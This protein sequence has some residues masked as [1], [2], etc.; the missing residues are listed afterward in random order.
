MVWWE[1]HK[2]TIPE[3]KHTEVQ[4]AG[5][6]GTRCV[7]MHVQFA[8]GGIRSEVDK[9]RRST[10]ALMKAMSAVQMVV[11]VVDNWYNSGCIYDP[12]RAD[13]C[14]CCLNVSALAVPHYA[15]HVPRVADTVHQ[16][17][18]HFLGLLEY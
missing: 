12:L 9:T 18:Y 10:V 3:G 13:C 15:S 5:G 17:T 6:R 11:W 4:V 7:L 8:C 1:L 16:S 2:N 14:D